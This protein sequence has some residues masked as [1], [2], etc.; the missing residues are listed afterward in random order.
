[1][2]IH[3]FPRIH[4]GINVKLVLYMYKPILHKLNSQQCLFHMYIA[5]GIAWL[6]YIYICMYVC[7][8]I[9][10]VIALLFRNKSWALLNAQVCRVCASE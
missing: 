1:M 2:F 5:Q 4:V 6:A 10:Y 9:Y 8:Y 3:K 7:I